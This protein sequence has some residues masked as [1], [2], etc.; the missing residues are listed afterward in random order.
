M[1]AGHSTILA[2][3][4]TTV[5]RSLSEAGR[6]AYARIALLDL[7]VGKGF[8]LFDDLLQPATALGMILLRRQGSSLLSILLVESLDVTDLCLQQVNT[9]KDRFSSI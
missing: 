9:V 7:A 8:Q 1:C 5:S 4:R 2:S 6:H 3:L